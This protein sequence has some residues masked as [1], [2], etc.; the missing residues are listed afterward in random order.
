MALSSKGID[1]H[2]ARQNA[3]RVILPLNT[4]KRQ[5]VRCF[6]VDDHPLFVSVLTDVLKIDQGFHLVGVA[7][8]GQEM[9]R[10]LRGNHV[11]LVVLDLQL[12]DISGIELIGVI[13]AERLADR[14]VICS[15]LTADEC[16]EV[17][18]ALGVDAYVQKTTSIDE[19]LDTLRAT[20]EGRV[21]MS[22]H[23]ARVLRDMIRYRRAHGGLKV[24]DYLVLI[25]LAEGKCPKVLAGELGLSTSA[26]YKITYRLA[27]RFGLKNQ[28][29]VLGLASRLGLF[30]YRNRTGN[31]AAQ[32]GLTVTPAAPDAHGLREVELPSRLP[33]LQS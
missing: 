25:G 5:P 6:V 9:L 12:P 26:I 11:D 8:T 7:H 22:A 4:E 1:R 15:G 28:V 33:P 32:V 30:S 19:L 18:F 3:R 16:I 24:R 20:V 23:V 29:E 2:C 21:P 10:Q 27:D 13:R 17:A 31:L 14:I